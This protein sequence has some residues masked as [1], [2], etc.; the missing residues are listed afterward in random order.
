MQTDGRK[1]RR[2]GLKWHKDKE[3]EQENSRREEKRIRCGW[4]KN[5][6][7]TLCLCA[8]MFRTKCKQCNAELLPNNGSS[9]RHIWSIAF[10]TKDAKMLNSSFWNR[11]QNTARNNT[12]SIISWHMAVTPRHGCLAAPLTQLPPVLWCSVLW[13]QLLSISAL[14]RNSL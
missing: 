4:E 10:Q 7:V 6:F 3:S 1:E 12:L 11:P 8:V 5:W 2:S 14:S 13:D 9:F